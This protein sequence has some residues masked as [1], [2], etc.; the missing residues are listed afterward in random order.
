[1]FIFWVYKLFKVNAEAFV[2]VEN[3]YLNLKALSHYT[4][5]INKKFTLFKSPPI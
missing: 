3:S 1:M 4:V 2:Y 5:R